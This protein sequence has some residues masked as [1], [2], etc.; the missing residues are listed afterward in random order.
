MTE[1]LKIIL[2][3]VAAAIIYGILHDQITARVCVEYFTIF[4]PP[5]FATQSPTLLAFG[6]GV[7][8]TW[9]VGLF[10][11]L[12][13]A[14]AARVGPHPK[15]S[16]RELLRP[17]ARLILAMACCALTAGI[18]GFFL[19]SHHLLPEP[20]W[21]SPVL[22]PSNYPRFMADWFAHNASY[23]SGFLGGAVLCVLQYRRRGRLQSLVVNS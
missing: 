20:E 4:H 9:W 6:W 15:L 14:L 2:A 7:I 17:I 16:V 18:T 12:F 21:M 10:L 8:A 11:G 22:T 23:A 1:H 5:V 19:A 3:C 13:L